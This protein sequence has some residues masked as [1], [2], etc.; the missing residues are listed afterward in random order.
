MLLSGIKRAHS[1]G[2]IK[3]AK[4]SGPMLKINWSL[5]LAVQVSVKISYAESLFQ[6]VVFK[7]KSPL[8]K[9]SKNFVGLTFYHLEYNKQTNSN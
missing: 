8:L 3:F 7:Q 5:H 6:N 1:T 2:D 4:T 9:E